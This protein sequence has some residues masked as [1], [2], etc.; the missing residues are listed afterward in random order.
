METENQL[1]LRNES[2]S[3][4]TTSLLVAD[5]FEKR[6]ADVIRSIESAIEV[7]AKLRSHCVISSYV[8][9]Q[10][11]ERPMYFIDKDGFSFVTMGF[12]GEKAAAFKW[13]YIE[14]F[15]TM[16]QKLQQVSAALP[17]F[18]DPA[19]AARAWA[20][21]YEGRLA[22]EVKTTELEKE[23]ETKEA[24]I[25]NLVKNF[26]PKT[27]LKDV[28]SQLNGV[29]LNLCL[30]ALEEKGFIAKI[31]KEYRDWSGVRRLYG[32]KQTSKSPSWFQ[33]SIITTINK[34]GEKYNSQR[35]LVTYIG[36]KKLCSLYMDGKL[37]MRKDWNGTY[38]FAAPDECCIHEL[39]EKVKRVA[40]SVN[41]KEI[42][43]HLCKAFTTTELWKPSRKA[44]FGVRGIIFAASVYNGYVNIAL[45]ARDS[46]V[47]LGRIDSDNPVLKAGGV[48]M[49]YDANTYEIVAYCWEP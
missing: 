6:H 35:L 5:K 44:M 20:I 2:G 30:S 36:L 7:N 9:A 43:R 16:E 49:E 26:T 14:C 17:N 22:L 24:A 13:E 19:E 11:K 41:R 29:N 33:P 40:L 4:V 42:S 12:T 15:N 3:T 21:Q 18:E 31:D 38:H 34:S 27:E 47:N 8:D 39:S 10:G 37:P 45:N 48:E 25:W 1:V 28:I 46:F 23:I 32:Y